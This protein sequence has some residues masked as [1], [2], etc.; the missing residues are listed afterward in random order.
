MT[1]RVSSRKIVYG[2]VSY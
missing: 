1:F 2:M